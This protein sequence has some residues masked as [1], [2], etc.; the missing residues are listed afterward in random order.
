MNERFP[1]PPAGY[2]GGATLPLD[3]TIRACEVP[4]CLTERACCCPAKAVV[5]VVMPPTSA[6]PHRTELLLCG[7]HYRVSRQSL[8]AARARVVQLPGTPGGTVA[9]IGLERNGY[10]APVN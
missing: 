7:H 5:R 2:D 8:G 10:P 4:A 9:W 1:H 6:R 3:N